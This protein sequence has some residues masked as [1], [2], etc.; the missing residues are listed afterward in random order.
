MADCGRWWVAAANWLSDGIWQT[1]ERFRR[2]R[3]KDQ[4]RF[5]RARVNSLNDRACQRVPSVPILC[6]VACS[7]AV[8][9]QSMIPQ[10]WVGRDINR[11]L[12]VACLI[13][14]R[15]T[16]RASSDG[17]EKDE[18]VTRLPHC[19]F[20]A[21]FPCGARKSHFAS[22]SISVGNVQENM[23]HLARAKTERR[24]VLCLRDHSAK[25]SGNSQPL[26]FS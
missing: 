17:Q 22:D 4:T 13:L 2:D 18:F 6:H 15:Q 7:K 24:L 12:A 26:V 21:F 10:N 3:A 25:R 14:T 1:A 11:G 9:S 8:T 5:D 20:R 16:V 23:G 19:G